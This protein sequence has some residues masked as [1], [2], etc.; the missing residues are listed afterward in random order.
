MSEEF[1]VRKELACDFAGIR[2]VNDR[3]FGAAG[4]GKLVD[5]LRADG[6]TVSSVVAVANGEVIGHALFSEL[7]IGSTRSEIRAV[8]L[9]P[10]AV[11]PE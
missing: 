5:K 8:A 3:A 9:A 10:V 7:R 4:E 11:L 6:L 1:A 2:R